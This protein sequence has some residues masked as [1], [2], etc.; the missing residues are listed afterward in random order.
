MADK[1]EELKRTD[2]VDEA[3][4]MLRSG[5]ELL[6]HDSAVINGEPKYFFLLGR[7]KE[8]ALQKL[9]KELESKHQE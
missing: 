9:V 4:S 6:Q 7:P 2:S 3:N 5:W 8:S 1:F